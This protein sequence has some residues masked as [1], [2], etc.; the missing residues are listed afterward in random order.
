MTFLPK[1]TTGKWGLSLSLAFA[2]LLVIKIAVALPLPSP[3]IFAIGLTGVVLNIIALFRNERSI[4]FYVL[5]GAI[6]SLVLFW[7]G[8]ELLFPH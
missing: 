7:A 2:V 6:S 4:V 3:F 1:T 8:A 5:G